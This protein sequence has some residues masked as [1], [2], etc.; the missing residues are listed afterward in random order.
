MTEEK[1]HGGVKLGVQADYQDHP[2]ISQRSDQVYQ[3]KEGA[4]G[5]PDLFRVCQSHEGEVRHMRDIPSAHSVQVLQLLRSK[6]VLTRNHCKKDL[7]FYEQQSIFILAFS[8][9]G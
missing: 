7:C 5:Q 3:E 4:E 9:K 8:E 6:L 1:T 2:H